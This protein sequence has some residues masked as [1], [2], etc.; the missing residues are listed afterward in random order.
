MELYSLLWLCWWNYIVCFGYVDG[1]IYIYI[2][3]CYVNGYSLFSLFLVMLIDIGM[4]KKIEFFDVLENDTS[5]VFDVSKNEMY[6]LTLLFLTFETSQKNRIKKISDMSDW[7]TSQKCSVK[8]YMFFCSVCLANI[9][10]HSGFASRRSGFASRRS[11]SQPRDGHLCLLAF[12]PIRWGWPAHRMAKG[13]A[14]PQIAKEVLKTSNL[15]S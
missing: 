9:K 11:F 7:L 2:L 1:T 8:N 3:F 4:S 5:K 14:T 6:F 13:G 15:F 12:H 10:N